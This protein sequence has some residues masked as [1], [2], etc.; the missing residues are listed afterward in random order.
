[1]LKSKQK[2]A[3]A[4]ELLKNTIIYSFIYIHTY[5]DTPLTL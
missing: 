4:K 5:M 2:Y 1:M 3:T